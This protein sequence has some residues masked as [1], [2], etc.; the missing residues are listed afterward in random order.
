[1]VPGIESDAIPGFS[2][3]ETRKNLSCSAGMGEVSRGRWQPSEV[4]LVALTAIG[5]LVFVG[6]TLAVVRALLEIGL[7][8][9]IATALLAIVLYRPLRSFV[10]A[11]WPESERLFRV[12]EDMADWLL[13]LV[14]PQSWLG[15]AI[16]W[17][18]ARLAWLSGEAGHQGTKPGDVEPRS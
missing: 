8:R 17:G 10:V 3:H 6:G 11:R 2:S 9:K 15:R 14:P 12:H 16:A 18:R 4:L 7:I 5:L 1:M 13:G